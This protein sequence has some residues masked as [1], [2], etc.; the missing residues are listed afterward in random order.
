MAFYL[1]RI[2]RLCLLSVVKE[3]LCLQFRNFNLLDDALKKGSERLLL[4]LQQR[5]PGKFADG[6]LRTLQ[7]RVRSWRLEQVNGSDSDNKELT[8]VPEEGR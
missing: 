2:S 8:G 5:Y 6:Q 4:A 3:I 7:R 1:G